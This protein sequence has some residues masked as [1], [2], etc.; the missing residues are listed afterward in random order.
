M[1]SKAATET[2]LFK[3]TSCSYNIHSYGFIPNGLSGLCGSPLSIITEHLKLR[4]SPR[5]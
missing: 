4:S 2:F 1:L 3:I 5:F